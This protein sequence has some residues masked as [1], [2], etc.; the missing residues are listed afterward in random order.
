MIIN[1]VNTIPYCNKWKE[2]ITFYK[3]ILC[4]PVLFTKEW[5]VEFEINETSRLSVADASRTSID[6]SDGKGITISMKVDDIYATYDTLKAK[7]IQQIIIKEQW[8]SKVIY[9]YDP[10]GNRLEFWS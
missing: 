1:I 7:G 4:F 8:G 2:T 10:D 9:L 3:D 6:S 5:F